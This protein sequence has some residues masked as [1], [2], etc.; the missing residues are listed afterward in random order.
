MQP[1]AAAERMQPQAAR[2]RRSAMNRTPA[3]SVAILLGLSVLVA[4]CGQA[5]PP[6]TGGL[7]LAAANVPRATADPAGAV[8]AATAID[9]FGLDLLRS[10]AKSDSNIV[11]SP[12]SVVLALAMAR[13]GARG[14]TAAQM[15]TVLRDVATDD[16]AAWLNAL[17][18]A[19]ASRSATFKDAQGNDQSVTLRIANAPFAQRGMTLV[20]GYLDALASRF[21]A[22]LRLV[23]YKAAAEAARQTINSWVSGQTEQRIRELL[24]SG[25]VDASTRLVLVNAIYLKAAWQMPFSADATQPAP[26][27]TADGSTVDVPMMHG[28]GIIPYA[29]GKGW[30]AVELPYVGGS[31]ALDVIVPDDLASFQKDL[32]GDSLAAAFAALESRQV[33]LSMPKFSL[34]TQTRSWRCPRSARDAIGVRR[35]SRGLLRDHARRAAVHLEGDPRGEHRRRREGHR[36]GGRDGGRHDS[37]GAGD[38]AGDHDGRSSVP[39][40]ASRPSDGHGAVPRPGG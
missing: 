4:A 37:R 8:D 11:V 26:F 6:S 13:A 18:A 27:T 14:E 30:R 35:R 5:A 31:L 12:A 20:P 22:G 39:V 2:E 36:G 29:D 17:D 28:G 33:N 21:G 38:G 1:Q 40:R 19:L 7:E 34:K 15:D 25:T 10:A 3:A 32:T 16:H 9:A 23:D 24:A